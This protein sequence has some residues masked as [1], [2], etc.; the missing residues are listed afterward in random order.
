MTQ[1][2][3]LAITPLMK[4]IGEDGCSVVVRFG[5]GGVNSA[6]GGRCFLKRGIRF[7]KR[8]GRMQAR[9]GAPRGKGRYVKMHIWDTPLKVR[10]NG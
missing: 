8:G 6:E 7:K 5:F 1:V 4:I 10:Q 9:R 3:G 2:S